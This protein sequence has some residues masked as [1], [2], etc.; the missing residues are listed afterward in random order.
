V[1]RGARRIGAATAVAAL[2][3]TTHRTI[4][5]DAPPALTPEAFEERA[6]VERGLLLVRLDPT[7]GAPPGSC[8]TLSARD[9][10][11]TVSGLEARVTS[12]EH[13]P[14]PD[15]HWLLIDTSE[16]AAG[17]RN[18]AKRS[19]QRYLHDV[20]KPGEDVAT[21]LTVDD[22]VVLV[23]G[24]SDDPAAL[25]A[26]VDDVPEAGASALRDGLDTVLRQ[27]AGERHEQLVLYWTDGLDTDSVGSL[28]DLLSTVERSPHATVFPIVLLPTRGSDMLR[29][30]A[31]TFLFDVAR[32][33]GGEVL[34]SSD[35]RW[36]DRVR[37]WIARRFAVSFAYPEEAPAGR[38]D[39]RLRGNACRATLLRD[40]FARP[41]PVAG[42]ALPVPAA[43]TRLH[44][45][46]RKRD[47]AACSGDARPRSWEEPLVDE[48]GAMAGC[49][50]D[51][52]RSPERAAARDV[53]VIAPEV[54]ALPESL[55]EVIDRVIPP[56]DGPSPLL[57]SGSALLAQRARIAAS[58]FAERRD[59]R[60]FALARLARVAEDDLGAIERGFARDMPG[61]SQDAIAAI[62]R[63]SRAG[64]RALEAAR[65][66]TDADLARVLAAWL[67]DVPA[68]SV[69]AEWERR[70]IDARIA[71]RPDPSAQARWTSLRERFGNAGVGG[72]LGPLV[73]IHDRER[74]V[75]GF[76]R[77]VLPRERTGIVRAD[78]AVPDRPLGL[79]LVDRI[80]TRPGVAE[81]LSSGAYRTARL[82]E[83]PG[84]GTPSRHAR[85]SVAL[86]SHAR[87]ARVV[88]DAEIAVDDHGAMTI[89]RFT[90][91]VSGD[92][93]LAALLGA[94]AEK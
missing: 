53:R 73:L 1:T 13:V 87:S 64:R 27:A 30:P 74:D 91:S 70:L 24:P 88:L 47:D 71:S 58:L 89:V 49:V 92:P 55:A 60:D 31:G 37:G 35:A 11:V 20:L 84:S 48:G 10:S 75:I 85:V 4:A 18:E 38:V 82:D 32:R 83:E 51:L 2:A 9:L 33:S 19:A 52:I 65:T 59:Y 5:R 42:A 29:P 86:A 26:R 41:D 3:V 6:L 44:D 93:D 28:E 62:A 54:A 57:V 15:R 39:V 67:A 79:L 45:R 23:S 78:E 34:S 81:S 61:E 90:P 8:D 40:P 56:R 21:L 66:P 68:R 72:I 63:A 7:R 94:P 50:L 69:F 76:D 80:A 17:R 36:L 77:I 22:D 16:S 25:A 46:Q 14:R 43:W 12:V